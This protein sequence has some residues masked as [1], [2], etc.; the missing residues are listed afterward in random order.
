[1]KP[2]EHLPPDS[3]VTADAPRCFGP[4]IVNHADPAQECVDFALGIMERPPTDFPMNQANRDPSSTEWGTSADYMPPSIKVGKGRCEVTVSWT[5]NPRVRMSNS[6]VLWRAI[7]HA[8]EQLAMG[9]VMTQNRVFSQILLEERGPGKGV[10]VVELRLNTGLDAQLQA[11]N[12]GT[13]TDPWDISAEEWARTRDAR[14]HLYF[15][16]MASGWME[17][18]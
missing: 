12:A 5:R 16:Y 13:D 2:R 17:Y 3:L 14:A 11:I 7:G 4:R 8:V 1:M 18:P 10:M 9:C 6:E 15:R